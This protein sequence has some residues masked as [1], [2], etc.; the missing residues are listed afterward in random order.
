[1]L[2]WTPA[3]PVTAPGHG[4]ADGDDCCGH[5]WARADDAGARRAPCRPG[6]RGPALAVRRAGPR[7]PGRGTSS[8]GRDAPR[9]GHA[10]VAPPGLVARTIAPCMASTTSC[11]KV[12]SAS[13]NPAAARPSRYSDR[14]RQSTRLNSSHV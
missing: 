9:A 7:P 4:K 14:D 2:S 13:T 12:T 8:R 10:A 1:T 6:E 11:V 3:N 5:T